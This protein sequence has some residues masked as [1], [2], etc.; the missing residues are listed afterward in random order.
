MAA[1]GI[2]VVRPSWVRSLA[3]DRLCV[4]DASTDNDGS[5]RVGKTR[6]LCYFALRIE[7]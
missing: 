6:A 3:Y 7:L 2:P 5:L 1:L 4:P